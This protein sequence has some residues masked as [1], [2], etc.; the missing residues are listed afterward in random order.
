MSRY[1]ITTDN[2]EVTMKDPASW[3]VLKWMEGESNTFICESMGSLSGAEYVKTSQEMTNY[4]YEN[5]LLTEADRPMLIKQTAR[6][7]IGEQVK[8]A[9]QGAGL[10]LRQLAELTGIAHNHISRIEQ[11]RYNVN[12]DTL[13]VIADALGLKPA[14]I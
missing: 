4:A 1:S 7:M 6:R 3:V 9:R 5:G 12:L 13:A 8:N 10:T 2:G 14:I 11:G